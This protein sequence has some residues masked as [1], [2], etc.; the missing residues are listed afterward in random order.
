M[1]RVHLSMKLTQRKAEA[2]DGGKQISYG[3]FVS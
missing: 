1:E 3:M 2:G